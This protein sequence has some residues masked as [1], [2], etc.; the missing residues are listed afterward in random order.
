ML[1]PIY[2]IES[3]PTLNFTII[4]NPNSGPGKG[5]LPDED[6]SREITRLNQHPNVTLVGYVPVNWCKRD[7]EKVCKDIDKYAAWSQHGNGELAVKGIFFDESPN[8]FKPK[9]KEY[10]DAADAR[11]KAAAGITGTRL[12]GFVRISIYSRRVC[13]QC[14]CQSRPSTTPARSQI[15]N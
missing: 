9:A 13:L 5:A 7:L 3:H 4:I 12:V 8:G 10:M 6:Y 1:K 15:L 2:R 14:S 11:V